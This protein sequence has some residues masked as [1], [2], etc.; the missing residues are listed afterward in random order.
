VT[1]K[2]GYTVVTRETRNGAFRTV[3]KS[4]KR[5]IETPNGWV[6]PE[7]LRAQFQQRQGGG[8]GQGGGAFRGLG[9]VIDGP[10]DII[11]LVLSEASDF[12]EVD[13]AIV[14]EL[15]L[16]AAG[17]MLRPGARAGQGSPPADAKGTVS[18]W[19]KDGIIAKISVHLT[20]TLQGRDGAER[21]V[22]R[23]T[24]T[25]IKDVGTTKVEV[26]AE[27]LAKLGA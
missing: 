18:V 11:A 4:D 10:A 7:E 1:E 17:R 3:A 24:V 13:G 2:D 20:G 23:T 6:T 16:A 14:G 27:A 9:G 25:E 8:G 21:K 15:S 19:L 12:K 22:D 5:A 26:P